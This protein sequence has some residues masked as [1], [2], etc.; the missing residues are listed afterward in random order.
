MAM[1]LGNSTQNAVRRHRQQTTLFR[2]RGLGH[3]GLGGGNHRINT[4]LQA[5]KS[6]SLEL[7]QVQT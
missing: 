6:L 2:A 1:S 7:K 4:P 3:V 5:E